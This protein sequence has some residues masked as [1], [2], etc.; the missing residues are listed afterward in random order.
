MAKKQLTEFVN[1]L[2]K[3]GIKVSLTKPKSNYLLSLQQ[4]KRYPSSVN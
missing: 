1:K 4:I 2:K 3:A